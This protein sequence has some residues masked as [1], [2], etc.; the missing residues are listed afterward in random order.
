MLEVQFKPQMCDI[1]STDK[2]YY[3]GTAF[4]LP[5]KIDISQVFYQIKVIKTSLAYIGI[6]IIRMHPLAT[7]KF[8]S[9]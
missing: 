9:T 6:I 8:F 4:T 3:L 1:D 2:D 5:N 7:V